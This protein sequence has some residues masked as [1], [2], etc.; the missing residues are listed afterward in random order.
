MKKTIAILLSLALLLGMLP[1]AALASE[2][3]TWTG[4]ISYA[5]DT[6]LAKRV[7]VS[8]DV[9][10]T[11]PAGVTLTCS[12]G[13]ALDEDSS[14]TIEGEGT[15]VAH[16]DSANR[17]EQAG[18]GSDWYNEPCALTINGGTVKAYGYVG[19]RAG[20]LTI[21]GGTVEAEGS[22]GIT[23]GDSLT[24]NG[25][26]VRAI[27]G[28][29]GESF[30][31]SGI[32]ADSILTINGGTVFAASGEGLTGNANGG[33]SAG[34]GELV[35]NGGFV[36]AEGAEN[37]PGI[38]ADG[39]VA[40]TG[41]TVTATGGVGAAG[42]GCS[43]AN[44]MVGS[45]TISGGTVTATGGEGGAGIGGGDRGNLSEEAVVSISGGTVTATGGEGGAGIGG[46]DDGDLDGAVRIEGGAKVK[47]VGGLEA[48][49][50]GGGKGGTM[51]DGSL[52]L[53]GSPTVDAAAGTDGTHA[54][55]AGLDGKEGVG[56]LQLPF[57]A[58]VALGVYSLDPDVEIIP[59]A[60]RVS[61]CEREARV[62]I[63]PCR[64]HSF[65]NGFCAFCGMSETDPAPGGARPLYAES[66]WWETGTYVPGGSLTIPERVTVTGD[67]R[68]YLP[69]GAELTCAKGIT[70]PEDSALTVE[71]GGTLIADSRAYSSGAGIGSD[72]GGVYVSDTGL[73]GTFDMYGGTIIGNKAENYGGGVYVSKGTGGLFAQDG[74]SFD[75]SG[76]VI[77]DNNAYKGGGVYLADASLFG[78][79]GAVFTITD[80][81]TVTCNN[82]E[83]G[84]GGGVYVS[85]GCEIRLR[86][87]PVINGNLGS[88]VGCN[89]LY[90]SSGMTIEI[91]S[92]LSENASV[93][94]RMQSPGV[95]TSHLADCNSGSV[96]PAAFFDSDFADYKVTLS[97]GEACLTPGWSSL[98]SGSSGGGGG[99]AA[100]ANP[101]TVPSTT[102]SMVAHGSVK[103]SAANARAGDKVTVTPEPDEGYVT[104]GITVTDAK[105]NNIPVTKNADGT[106][107][108]TMPATAVTITP[109][110]EEAGGQPADSGDV[111]SRF[112]DVTTDAW[113]RDAVA[114][115][116]EQGIMNGV[117]DDTFAPNDNTTRAM[118]VTMLWRMAGEPVVNEIIPYIDVPEDMW[119]TEAIR[120]AASTGAVTGM[121]ADIFSPNEPVT[122]EQLAAILYRFAQAQGKGFTGAWMFPLDYSDA[123]QV[124]DW[125]NEAMHWMTMH[126]IITGMDDGTLAP[127]NNATRAQIA[128]M[129]M[130]FADVMAK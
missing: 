120:W 130:R 30:L 69:E 96:D 53:T 113:F 109:T 40:I 49:G 34:E 56:A 128:T 105:G 79:R 126:G 124:S 18:I 35:I 73:A 17:N 93:S 85:S 58:R 38:S 67:V 60:Q 78:S 42:I 83:K 115:A 51:K 46:G 45:V 76:G 123:D 116:V 8:G 99:A 50:I 117:S 81:S 21:N 129:F 72:G 97:G 94:V 16:R 88:E 110:F 11:L 52:V 15:L 64:D 122:R 114:W 25:G 57:D 119:Y 22:L 13:I 62:V 31:S 101:V 9:T 3:D 102:E 89:N 63:E 43:S 68:L 84:D 48:A 118:V 19:I 59:V 127:H 86:D 66:V 104:A 36:T 4:A 61:A 6:V 47:A 111:S 90:L 10:L 54:V 2:G 12:E 107:S 37:L 70:V 7:T 71:V 74:G 125:A 87:D 39:T 1:T 103:S 112:K 27:G 98:S 92:K 100:A 44:D 20:D 65:E 82:V 77:R 32:S 23:A 14:L 33:I 106:Y 95:F 108:F 91:I 24:I 55:G 75:M 26:T 5:S 121:S 29:I 28:K 80:D 41:G